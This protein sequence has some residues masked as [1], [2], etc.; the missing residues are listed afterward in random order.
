MKHWYEW[1]CESSLIIAVLHFGSGENCWYYNFCMCVWFFYFL[2][3]D[4]TVLQMIDFVT[5]GFYL[6]IEKSCKQCPVTFY[7]CF[8]ITWNPMLLMLLIKVE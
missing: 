1:L 2:L 6:I 3:L 7:K 5:P 8:N 4:Y